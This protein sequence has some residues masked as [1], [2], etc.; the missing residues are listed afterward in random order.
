MR[1]QGLE[2]DPTYR[3]VWAPE[4]AYIHD[5]IAE[6]LPPFLLWLLAC[7]DPAELRAGYTAGGLRLW[8][9]PS[10]RGQVHVFESDDG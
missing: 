5:Q 10:R 1:D 9:T 8:S 3:G 4:D 6:H 2:R 7:C